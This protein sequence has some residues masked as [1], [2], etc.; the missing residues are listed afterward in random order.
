[1]INFGLNRFTVYAGSAEAGLQ[2]MR[3]VRRDLLAHKLHIANLYF[4]LLLLTIGCTG[5]PPA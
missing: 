2:C 3:E 1:V 4:S 5:F